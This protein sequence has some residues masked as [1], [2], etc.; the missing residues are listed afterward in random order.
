MRKTPILRYPG[1]FITCCLFSHHCDTWSAGQYAIRCSDQYITTTVARSDSAIRPSLRRRNGAIG[2]L[3]AGLAT[4]DA[5]GVHVLSDRAVLSLTRLC[6]NPWMRTRRQ[7]F[8][9]CR[10]CSASRPSR[11]RYADRSSTRVSEQSE[12]RSSNAISHAM[13]HAV[14]LRTLIAWCRDRIS[15]L[16]R[17]SGPMDNGQRMRPK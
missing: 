4:C 6:S 5:A 8:R 12:T 17:P 3:R 2:P 16:R 1:S 15:R 13:I 11:E 7:D 14:S 10:Y 9:Y